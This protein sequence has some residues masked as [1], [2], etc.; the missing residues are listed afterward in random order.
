M[1]SDPFA[2]FPV[3]ANQQIFLAID[4][5]KSSWTRTPERMQLTLISDATVI[6]P[7]Y[8]CYLRDNHSISNG[9]LDVILPQALQKGY[10][11]HGIVAISRTIKLMSEGSE[12]RQDGV[13]IFHRGQALA[14]I[15]DALSDVNDDALPLAVM[16]M[17]SLD[18]RRIIFDMIQ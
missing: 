13:V 17:V 15:K 5:C 2:S 1:R 9:C 12:A 4:H 11:F 6:A 10:L 3:P 8:G 16:H 14:G 18:V 7:M